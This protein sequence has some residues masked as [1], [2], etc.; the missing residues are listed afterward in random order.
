MYQDQAAQAKLQLVAKRSAE[1]VVAVAT[2][3]ENVGADAA[4]QAVVIVVA[5]EDVVA[6]MA[7]EHV[8]PR[9]AVSGSSP[10]RPEICLPDNYQAGTLFP[11]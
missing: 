4:V 10:A 6:A 7:V 9:P 5:D 2:N 3:N 8:A 1:D 11:A